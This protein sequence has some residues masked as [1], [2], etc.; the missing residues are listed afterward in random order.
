MKAWMEGRGEGS[1]SIEGEIMLD[2]CKILSTEWRR[3]R[4]V[5]SLFIKLV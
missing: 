2:K 4:V 5:T 3:L 1:P